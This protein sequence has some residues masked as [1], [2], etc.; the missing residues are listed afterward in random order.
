MHGQVVRN[1]KFIHTLWVLTKI[2]ILG[3]F[4]DFCVARLSK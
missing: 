4:T 3:L 2:D 1:V